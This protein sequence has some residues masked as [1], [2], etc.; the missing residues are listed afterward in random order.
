M[1]RRSLLG[2]IVMFIICISAAAGAAEQPDEG[3]HLLEVLGIADEID[4]NYNDTVNRSEFASIIIRLMNFKDQT[5]GG[6]GKYKDV[7]QNAGDIEAVSDLGFMQGTG[8]GYFMPDD[9]VTYEQVAT[10]LIRILGY[11]PMARGQYPDGYLSQCS[12]LGIFDGISN[13]SYSDNAL[14]TVVYAMI[15]N[16]LDVELMEA[17]QNGVYV[18]NGETILSKQFSV[19]KTEGIVT[20]NGRTSLSG[21][22]ACGVNEIIIGDMVYINYDDET[23]QKLGYNIVAFYKD[24]GSEKSIIYSYE[25]NNQIFE[26]K[27]SDIE[28]FESRQYSIREGSRKRTYRV[29]NNAEIIYNKRGYSGSLNDINFVPEYGSVI[30]VDNNRDGIMDVM[31]IDEYKIYAAEAIKNNVVYL[32]YSEVPE[33]NLNE[34]LDFRIIDKQGELVEQ[35][36]V[37]EWDALFVAA[38]PD[39]SYCEIIVS[40]EK[41]SGVFETVSDEWCVISGTGYAVSEAFFEI[42]GNDMSAGEEGTCM[43]DL[44][45]EIIYFYPSDSAY[46]KYAYTVKCNAGPS[47]SGDDEALL[48]LFDESGEMRTL[49]VAERA[50]IDNMQYTSKSNSC[51]ALNEIFANGRQ[52][53]RYRTNDENEIIELDTAAAFGDEQKELKNY[54]SSQSVVYK[55][56]AS[57][58][59]GKVLIDAS[60]KIFIVPNDDSEKK[61]NFSSVTKSHFSNDKSYN[62][63]GYSI[64]DENGVA[65]AVVCYENSGVLKGN[66]RPAIISDIELTIN[67]ENETVYGLEVMSMGS[68]KKLYTESVDTVGDIS[69]AVGDVI[70]YQT[71]NS[72]KICILQ[73]V[74]DESEDS[75]KLSSDFT[76]TAYN[77]NIRIANASVYA[78]EGRILTLTTNEPTE[79]YPD[80]AYMCFGNLFSI[81]VYNKIT[82]IVTEGTYQDATAYLSM[83]GQYSKAIVHT[84][85][86]D[87]KSMFIYNEE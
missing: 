27:Y 29:D 63:E 49:Y 74:Y 4:Y 81:Y 26:A 7:T 62:I 42:N 83:P 52:L 46:M 32:K 43:L 34:Y 3:M 2:A 86:G 5:G 38:A 78:R 64:G 61:E 56:A 68:T 67:E 17:E 41:V 39:G 60:T 76:N 50:K 59:G 19:Y 13:V 16:A 15:Y 10:V 71:D 75:F 80:D 77:A 28:S 1:K 18:K 44:F 65:K 22:R 12:A 45:D 84:E 25:K 37:V 54:Y 53:I 85:W 33:I 14:E 87:P 58:F 6:S 11:E 73:M 66:E 69:L 8:D 82:G 57:G 70:R 79:T 9:A 31:F 36:S 24:D 20:A 48:K 55:A 40:N 35:D 47:E 23:A 21:T 30:G 72:G 51:K